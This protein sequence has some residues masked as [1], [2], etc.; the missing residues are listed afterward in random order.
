[1]KDAETVVEPGNISG[2]KEMF[3][4]IPVLQSQKMLSMVDAKRNRF[5]SMVFEAVEVTRG[6]F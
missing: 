2:E 5:L 1:M 3:A 4:N 6:A